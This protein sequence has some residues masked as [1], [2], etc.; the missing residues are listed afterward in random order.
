[1]MQ[2]GRFDEA[3]LQEI[4]S[5]I[6]SDDRRASE[7]IRRLRAMLRKRPMTLETLSLHEVVDETIT[8]V[9]NDS[10]MRG[11]AMDAKTAPDLPPIRADRIQLQQVLLNLIMNGFEAMRDM[12][13]SKVLTIRGMRTDGGDLCVCVSDLGPGF[14][15][16]ADLQVM[17]QPFYS[18][19]DEG[20][21][22]GL[23]ISRSIIEAMGGKIWAE[24]NKG[25]GTTFHFT[26]PAAE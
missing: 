23:S 17:F 19:K 1:M 11:I 13:D 9:R 10:M 16:D 2:T 15:D 25:R 22:M 7:V 8:L 21:G 14:P 3:E 20:M 4:L 26:I 6:I 18:T 12:P 5:D 24:N